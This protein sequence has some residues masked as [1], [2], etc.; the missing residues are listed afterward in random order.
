MYSKTS[1]QEFLRHYINIIDELR[2]NGKV[3]SKQNPD[4]APYLD[5]SYR[6]SND[7]ETERLIE[8]FAYMF[9]QIEH[10]SVL[11]LNDY[12]INFID[13][14]FPELISPVSALTV[15]KLTPELNSFKNTNQLLL[16]KNTKFSAF[17]QEKFECQ[18]SST[19]E[20]PL[21]PFR[22]ESTS[23][24]NFNQYQRFSSP[25]TKAF[26]IDFQLKKPLFEEKNKSLSIPIYIDSDFYTSI[27]IYDA[28]FSSK[29]NFL[30]Y[31]DDNP[32]PVSLAR[33]QISPYIKFESQ[34][35]KNNMLYPF[36]DYLNY[37]QK[38][39]FFNLN[40]KL[41]FN[42]N[43]KLKIVVPFSYELP[44]LSKLGN[45]FL[46]VNCVPVANFFETKLEPIKCQKDKD[47][48]QVRPMGNFDNQTEL[49]SVQT[50]VT[51]DA[52]TG[53]SFTLKNFHNDKNESNQIPSLLGFENI[54]WSVRRSFEN[55]TQ[56]N[57]SLFIR[58]MNDV[59]DLNFGRWP[60]YL[61]PEGVCTNGILAT[62]IKP[63]TEF[64]CRSRDIKIKNSVSLF[65]P[66][67][68]R[69][70]LKHFGNIEVLKLLYKL[71]Q[72]L[73]SK[74]MLNVYEFEKIAE[75]MTSLGNP[76]RA[77]IKQFLSKSVNIIREESVSQQLW[78][79]QVYYIPGITYKI[80]FNKKDNLPQGTYFILNF[81]NSYFEYIRDFNFFIH[82]EVEQL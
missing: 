81:M 11:A 66:K 14:L 30:L 3:F 46:N 16:P 76:I 50:I 2:E 67:Y 51:Y 82:F 77:L 58:V 54:L 42:A 12:A 34:D 10:K 38:Y 78:K 18:F 29:Q 79:K 44:S 21:F 4:L 68:S 19:Q 24:V 36:F 80:M 37:F 6:K 5:L 60:D 52:K 49:L 59:K 43:S 71:D 33:N 47:E 74:N 40:I 35:K 25:H 17:N 55:S 32:I 73:M 39:L 75:Y 8:S 62:S 65:W 56:D 63:Y 15:L 20:M 31:I 7:P 57:G 69:R 48:Y 23:I 28:L 53:D 9:A 13:K 41:N 61:F 27:F 72:D 70:P 45:Q 26:S 22:I 64:K 1:N